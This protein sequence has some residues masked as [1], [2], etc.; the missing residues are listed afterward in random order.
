MQEGSGKEENNVN[1]LSSE[2]KNQMTS[3]PKFSGT[4]ITKKHKMKFDEPRNTD[5]ENL[6]GPPIKKNS[7]L[8][9]PPKPRDPLPPPKPPNTDKCK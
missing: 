4:D 8:P 1:R 6:F 3:K 9:E 5:F 2:E 7:K